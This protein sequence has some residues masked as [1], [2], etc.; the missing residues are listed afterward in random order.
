M[1]L[2]TKGWKRS[3]E[4]GFPK[5]VVTMQPSPALQSNCPFVLSV[6]VVFSLHC[7]IYDIY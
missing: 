2:E 6:H 3:E 4:H 5:M 1:S 7:I